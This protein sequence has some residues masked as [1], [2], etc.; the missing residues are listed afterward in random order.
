[1]ILPLRT[2]AV[3][4]YYVRLR[5]GVT[6]AEAERRIADAVRAAA[7]AIPPTWSGVRLRAMQEQYVEPVRPMLVAISFAAAIALAIVCANVV[8]LL[9]LRSTRRQKE[10]AVRLA[11]GAGRGQVIS[12]IV[13]EALI[14]TAAATAVGVAVTAAG[15]RTL[16]PIVE[17]N[18]GRVA[19]GGTS[20]IAI[21]GAVLVA[22]G[23]IGSIV[24]L[25]LRLETGMA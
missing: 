12:M 10:V 22:V 9:L 21:D 13:A 3:T 16:A 1:M 11:L 18:L 8:V 2:G 5:D 19:P 17:Q 14:L 4:A 25:A 20:A 6:L 24:A 7:S 23:G 15:L